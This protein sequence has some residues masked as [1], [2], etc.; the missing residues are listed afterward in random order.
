MKP[1]P[2]TV[3]TF[4]RTPVEPDER[5]PDARGASDGALSQLLCEPLFQLRRKLRR[6]VR[7][8]TRRQRTDVLVRL[9]EITAAAHDLLDWTLFALRRDDAMIGLAHALA[10]AAD[11]L[12][13]EATAAWKTPAAKDVEVERYGRREVNQ[14][15]PRRPRGGRALP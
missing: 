7:R 14:L 10:G 4:P 13:A 2:A 15:T 9:N 5:D 6:K 8:I 1:L 3:T 11:D 12:C